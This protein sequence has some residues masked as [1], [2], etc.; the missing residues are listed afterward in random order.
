MAL[1]FQLC[2][3]TQIV[4][5]VVTVFLLLLCFCSIEKQLRPQSVHDTGAMLDLFIH[6]LS[7]GK[8]C[9]ELI[10][11]CLTVKITCRVSGSKS[12]TSQGSK[13]I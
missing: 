9:C 12:Q 4:T 1:L 13:Q 6:G 2:D 3:V 7:D 5:S 10:N 11:S 8:W